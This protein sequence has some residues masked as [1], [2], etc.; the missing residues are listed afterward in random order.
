MATDKQKAAAR[1]NLERAR[2]V[3]SE[4]AHGEQIPKLSRA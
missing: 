1:Q 3:Q 4:R 2:E